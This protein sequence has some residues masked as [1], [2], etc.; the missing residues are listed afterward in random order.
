MATERMPRAPNTQRRCPHCQQ[1][2]RS[3]G[4]FYEHVEVIQRANGGI[5]TASEA[6]L[7]QLCGWC[8]G[9][10]EPTRSVVVTDVAPL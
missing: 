9:L 5:T 4:R 6:R 2:T 10:L 7:E 3:Y 8:G 1:L